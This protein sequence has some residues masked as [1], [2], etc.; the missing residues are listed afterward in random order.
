MFYKYLGSW[1]DGTQKYYTLC[2]VGFGVPSRAR[3]LYGTDFNAQSSPGKSRVILLITADPTVCFS[4]NLTTA[5]AFHC[6]WTTSAE[7]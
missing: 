1:K 7:Q 6:D 5:T 4:V 2:G 3:L